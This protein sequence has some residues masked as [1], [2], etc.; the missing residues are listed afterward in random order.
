M[1]LNNHITQSVTATQHNILY[2]NGTL[3]YVHCHQVV[4][5]VNCNLTDSIHDFSIGVKKKAMTE[6]IR[7]TYIYIYIYKDLMQQIHF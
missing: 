5:G 7:L 2:R 4:G 1:I 6:N 3:Q